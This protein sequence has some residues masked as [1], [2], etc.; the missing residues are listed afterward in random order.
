VGK[1]NSAAVASAVVNSVAKDASEYLAA[2]KVFVT[3][4]VKV[5]R[6][7]EEQSATDLPQTI[8]VQ[9]FVTQPC[10]IYVQD[11]VKKG[12]NYSSAGY[13]VGVLKFCYAEELDAA[14]EWANDFVHTALSEQMPEIVALVNKLGE[15]R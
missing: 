14:K 8:E 11:D 6:T 1:T 12:K 5:G 3:R 15:D 4:T 2:T 13:T 10:A 7:G 9:R